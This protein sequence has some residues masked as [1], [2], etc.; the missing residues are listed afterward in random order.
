[1]L[2]VA[3]FTLFLIIMLSAIS[4]V[5]SQQ[6]RVPDALSALLLA[7]GLAF[8]LLTARESLTAQMFGGCALA[9]TLLLIR[10]GHSRMTGRIG[11]GLGDVKLAGAGA[12]WIN[13]LLL[14][15]FVFAASASGL[16]YALFI[17][18]PGRGDRLPFA[19]FLAFG[20]FSCWL[21]EHYL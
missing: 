5:D 13:P 11:L 17:A 7:G 3:A 20:L 8:W 6:M 21:T 1:M 16:V 10:F 14:P 19:P 18:K 12:V 4:Y 15:F 9:C 2:I